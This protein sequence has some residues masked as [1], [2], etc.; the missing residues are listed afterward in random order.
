MGVEEVDTTVRGA[1]SNALLWLTNRHADAV[2]QG[3]RGLLHAWTARK[4]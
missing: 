4:R 2:V 1:V 3:D